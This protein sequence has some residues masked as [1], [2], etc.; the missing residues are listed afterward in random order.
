MNDEDLITQY[1]E[2][3]PHRPGLDEARLKSYGVAVW[4]LIGY[5]P[6]VGNDVSQVA[7]DY[8]VPVEAVEAAIAYYRRHR[9]LIDARIAANSAK[10]DDLLHP[11]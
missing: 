1:I 9:P 2:L 6:A 10:F 11:A 5:L 7:H 8:D 4:A 3:N